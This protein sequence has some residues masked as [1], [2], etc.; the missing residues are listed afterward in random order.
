LHVINSVTERDRAVVE[1]YLAEMQ[2]G[3]AGLDNLIGLFTDDAVYLEPWT[4]QAQ[5]H[6][7]K[8]EIRAFYAAALE[9]MQGA[10][11]TLDRLDVDG[12]RVRSEWTCE[13][14]MF[15]GPMRG[16]DLLTLREGR[17]ARLETTITEMPA[18]PN[19]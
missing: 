10:R 3:S 8:A 11:L 14:P 17:I 12:E 1:S 16:F 4:G 2:A 6:T 5:I 7:G 15:P 13:I 18:P 19:A 9:R